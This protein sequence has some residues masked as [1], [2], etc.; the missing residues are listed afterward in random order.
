MVHLVQ[1]ILV[2]LYAWDGRE[3]VL[4]FEEVPDCLG[5]RDGL[6]VA[7]C[8][9]VDLRAHF[10]KEE[11]YSLAV[12]LVFHLGLFLNQEVFE[13]CST[14]SRWHRFSASPQ[15]PRLPQCWLRYFMP[16]MNENG[17]N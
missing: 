17:G 12:P 4:C 13:P 2:V 1:A 15:V 14:F 10:L 7:L 3:V 9:G 16:K 6:G 8:S 11:V 5:V